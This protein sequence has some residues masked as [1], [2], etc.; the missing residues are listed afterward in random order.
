MET[1]EINH[2]AE[3]AQK[4][5]DAAEYDSLVRSVESSKRTP[6]EKDADR[7]LLT[8]GYLNL[9]GDPLPEKVRKLA[10]VDWE[11]IKRTLR[12]SEKISRILEAV[13]KPAAPAEPK[14]KLARILAFV[15]RCRRE[16]AAI[17]I[18]FAFAP[19]GPEIVD[20]IAK[21]IAR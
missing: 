18:A 15:E 12:D 2:T 1:T 21:A 9:N 10:R 14:G 17:L 19:H 8:A 13:E 16:I 4:H 6:G 20:R 7:A 5:A 3:E 11:Q